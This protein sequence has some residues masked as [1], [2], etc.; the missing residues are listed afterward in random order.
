MSI[1]DDLQSL[2]P[3]DPGRWPLP[4]ALGTVVAVFVLAVGR[5]SS[6]SSCGPDQKPRCSTARGRRSRSCARPSDE[7]CQGRESRGLPAAARGHREVVRRDAAP[8]A[9]QDRSAEPAG[10]HLADRRRRGPRRKALPAVGRS[11]EGLL[12][13]A[14]DQDPPD[15]LLSPDGRVRQ[16]HRG[17]AAHRH[18]CTT[19]RS[20][21]KTRMPTTT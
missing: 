10:R 19:S 18:A 15:R 4:C 14:A 17:A 3:N 9:G 13:R 6:T 11:E 20:S 2:D 21:R 8:A 16:R 7:A 1:L 12:R 5:C